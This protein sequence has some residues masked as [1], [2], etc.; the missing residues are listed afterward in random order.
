MNEVTKL[1]KEMRFSIQ[2]LCPCCEQNIELRSQAI[3]ALEQQQAVEPG[4]FTTQFRNILNESRCCNFVCDGKA[5][6]ACTII[7]QQA[8]KIASLISDLMKTEEAYIAMESRCADAKAQLDAYR[9]G[10]IVKEGGE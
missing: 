10:E 4:E 8:A 3:A 6:T 7:D 1:L 5:S 9:A 2:G